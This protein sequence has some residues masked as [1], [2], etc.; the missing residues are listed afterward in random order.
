MDASLVLKQ[1]QVESFQIVSKTYRKHNTTIA[2]QISAI[3][4]HYGPIGG[5]SGGLVDITTKTA[6][7]NG[8]K[9]S[10]EA[11]P[12]GIISNWLQNI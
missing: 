6:L 1:D 2:L 9:P 5:H 8:C 4:N 7:A 11:R 10:F 12:C 3:F